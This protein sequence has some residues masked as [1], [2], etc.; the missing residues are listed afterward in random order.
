MDKSYLLFCQGLVAFCIIFAPMAAF[1]N[2]SLS[3]TDMKEAVATASQPNPP[4]SGPTTGPAAQKDKQI[5]IIAEDLK[6]GGILGVAQGVAEAARILDWHLKVFDA[7]GTQSGREDAFRKISSGTFDGLVVI[8]S[9]A[10]A[11]KSRLQT[12][13]SRNIPIVGWHVSATPGKLTNS[14]LAV[15]VS[16]DPLK[17]AQ[18]TAMSA[19][20]QSTGTAGFVI[21]TD[22][23]FNIAI[24]KSNA[25]A[26]VIRACAQCTLLEIKDVP[27]S[28]SGDRIGDITRELLLKYGPRWT[29]ALAIN[30]VYFDDMMPELIKA[31]PQGAHVKLLSAGDGSAAA[32]QRIITHSFQYGTVA[33]PLNL[34][35]WQLADELNRLLAGQP[36]NGFVFPVHLVTP[37]NVFLDGGLRFIFDPQNNYREIYKG[38]WAP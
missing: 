28:Q 1:A 19:V 23:N 5:A 33:E 8:G 2:T 36:V 32:F 37:H 35:G 16:T 17:V 30:D 22:S 15:N 7:G 27:I 6:N 26:D 9:D 24:S 29:Y 18:I 11:S 21:F 12:I 31:G 20:T 13:A 10:D 3:F 38:I 25:M 14:P 4:W 34:H